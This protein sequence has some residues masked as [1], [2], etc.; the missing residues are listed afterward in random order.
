VQYPNAPCS[1]SS[2][3]D[4]FSVVRVSTGFARLCKHGRVVVN[5]SSIVT[6]FVAD[7]QVT[8]SVD[9]ADGQ[10]SPQE[11]ATVNAIVNASAY[12]LSIVLVG[13][14]DGP[15]DMMQEFD[16]NLPRRMFDNFQFI[17]FTEVMQKN[18]PPL[19][20]EAQFALGALME[21]PHQYKAALQ[22]KLLGM[23]RGSSPGGRPLLPPP[24]V[25]QMEGRPSPPPQ[26]AGAAQNVYEQYYGGYNNYG[27]APL[28]ANPT[29]RA[30]D[31][32]SGENTDCP[33]CLIDRK[34]MAFNCGHQTCQQCASSLV[35]CPICREPITTKIRL[36]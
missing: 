3:S 28:E 34:N 24:K 30:P 1:V 11:Q 26:D 22:L 13:V 2:C 8:R 17:N 7:G 21:I 6:V 18:L 27:Q 12:A 16:D 15:W 19:Q 33:V 31:H 4:F 29:S 14:G 23:P 25:L 10:L 32:A 9:M 5:C 36:Y 35:N 20:R